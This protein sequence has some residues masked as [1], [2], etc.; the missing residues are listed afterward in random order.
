MKN[1]ILVLLALI[2]VPAQAGDVTAALITQAGVNIELKGPAKSVRALVAD[3]EKDTAYKDAG[4]SSAP[5]K[6][7]GKTAKTKIRCAKPD[8]TLM[9]F[10]SK[11][12]PA[13]VHWSISSSGTSVA[14]CPTGCILTNCPPPNGILRCC[15]TST[16]QPC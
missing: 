13:Q 14:A 10:L 7:S 2:A 1:L 11:N 15:N 9:T 12:A 8:G 5:A 3:L 4:C 16:W 6:K